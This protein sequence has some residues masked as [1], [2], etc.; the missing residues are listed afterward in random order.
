M[1]TASCVRRMLACL[2]K[3]GSSTTAP[4][5]LLHRLDDM[6]QK[7]QL[8]YPRVCCEMVGE[9]VGRIRAAGYTGADLYIPLDQVSVRQGERA[10]VDLRTHAV[11]FPRLVTA[12]ALRGRTDPV[13][14]G[15]RGIAMP[16]VMP[17]DLQAG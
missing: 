7:G 16:C 13:P 4:Q 3:Q 15:V 1:L 14:T 2:P 10:C 11:Q 6:S 17:A 12:V 5:Y 8:F 9:T